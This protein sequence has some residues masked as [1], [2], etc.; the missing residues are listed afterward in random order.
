MP[1]WIGQA[2]LVLSLIM[3]GSFLAGAWWIALLL[4]IP[5]FALVVVENRYEREV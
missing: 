3:C 2:G 4:L 1:H 5:L